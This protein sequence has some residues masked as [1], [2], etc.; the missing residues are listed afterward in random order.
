MNGLGEWLQVA[1]LSIVVLGGVVSVRV[2]LAK[3]GEK[4]DQFGARLDREIGRLES[5]V[6]FIR[7]S[8]DRRNHARTD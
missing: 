3:L 1:T 5:E 4:V 2:Q 7:E 8:V 6:R